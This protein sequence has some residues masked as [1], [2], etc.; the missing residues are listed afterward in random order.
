MI[1]A[2]TCEARVHGKGATGT[3]PYPYRPTMLWGTLMPA[4]TMIA[5]I[6]FR[7]KI[8]GYPVTVNN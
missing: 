1:F 7:F 8:S 5:E 3:S 4:P 6:L 2:V